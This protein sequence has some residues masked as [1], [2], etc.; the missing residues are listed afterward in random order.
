MNTLNMA[1]GRIR[2]RQ[3]AQPVMVESRSKQSWPTMVTVKSTTGT[4]CMRKG[5]IWVNWPLGMEQFSLGVLG[6]LWLK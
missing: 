4:A 1:A 3:S 6:F 5:L 2:Y